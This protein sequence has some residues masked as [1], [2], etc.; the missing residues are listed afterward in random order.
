MAIVNV[1]LK[2]FENCINSCNSCEQSCIQCMT[3]CLNE[4]DV[5]ARK[6]CIT[7]LTECANICKEAS[8]FMS[9]DSKHAADLC[10]LCGTICDECAKE[11]NMFSDPHCKQCATDCQTCANECRSMASM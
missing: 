8:A 7:S 3:L 4:P 1:A 10:N 6:N 5:K 11:C 9:M 2:K